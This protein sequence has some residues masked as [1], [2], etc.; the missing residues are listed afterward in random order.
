M[1]WL[2]NTPCGPDFGPLQT[3]PSGL[4]AC[5]WSPSSITHTHTRRAS[6][7]SRVVA[8]L[9]G[10][11]VPVASAGPVKVTDQRATTHWQAQGTEHGRCCCCCCCCCWLILHSTC[12]PRLHIL[13]TATQRA[14]GQLY[15]RRQTT[16]SRL[17]TEANE[18][19]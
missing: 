1:F 3:P 14:L 15:T 11:A 16:N 19:T 2:M 6:P 12:K 9:G 8:Q 13:T 7:L 10:P 4:G 17:F 5:Q 18:R